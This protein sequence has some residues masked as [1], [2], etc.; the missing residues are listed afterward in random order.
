MN[1]LHREFVSQVV[2]HTL[3]SIITGDSRSYHVNMECIR[4]TAAA[5]HAYRDWDGCDQLRA[6]HN[7][8]YQLSNRTNALKNYRP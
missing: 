5:A 6:V 3:Q 2:T 1:I 4:I 7:E 8:L